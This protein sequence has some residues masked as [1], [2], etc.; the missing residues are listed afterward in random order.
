[1]AC[2]VGPRLCHMLREKCEDA[3]SRVRRTRSVSQRLTAV[4]SMLMHP[5]APQ[6]AD[7]RLDVPLDSNHSHYGALFEEVLRAVN[8]PQTAIA[9]ISWND[10]RSTPFVL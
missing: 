9:D 3:I 1:M 2:W 4:R 10:G 5:S 7:S 8:L 6:M